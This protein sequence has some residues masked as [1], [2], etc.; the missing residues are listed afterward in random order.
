[1]TA[2][3]GDPTLSASARWGVRALAA[4]VALVAWQVA[5][6]TQDVLFAPPL[7]VARVLVDDAL[8]TRVLLAAVV[9]ALRNAAVGYGL[10]L[11]VGVPVGALVGLWAP[12]R[13]V[14]D[15]VL[16]A[17][18][19]TPMVALAPLFI[20]WFGLSPV[21]KVVLVF[22]FA[23]FVVV[24]NTEAGL[25]N[26]PDGLLDAATVYGAGARAVRLRVRVRHALPS[27]L[28][29]ARLGAGRAVRGAV[30]AE[31]FLYADALGQYLIDSGSTF[32]IARLL[33]GVVALTLVGVLVVGS[34]GAVER[35]VRYAD[36]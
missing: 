24:I 8:S 23:V 1:V 26:P 22:T 15:P 31:L 33:A 11:T 29:G 30:A 35:R 16:D 20:I 36:A 7:A 14:L 32:E 3:G 34:V 19:S 21:A 27:V 13:H 28:T 5:A 2:L 18:Y 4:A 9:G 6:A 12:A 10:A 25:A 17:L